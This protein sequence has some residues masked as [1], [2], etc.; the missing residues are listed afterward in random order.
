MKSISLVIFLGSF[1]A[2]F[3]VFLMACTGEKNQQDPQGAGEYIYA[4]TF[5]GEG[6]EGL[7]VFE[8]NRAD[9]SLRPIQTVTDRVGPN[10][11]A[12][13]P[14]KQFLYSVGDDPYNESEPFGTLSAYQ[15]NQENGMLELINEQSV[16]GRNTAHVSVDPLGEFVYVSNYTEGNVVMFRILDNGGV[17]E[18]IDAKQHEGSSINEN[19]QNAPH[20]HQSVPSA[21]GR[22]LYVSDLGIDKIMIYEIDR[23]EGKLVPA[24]EPWFESEPGSG[25]RHLVLHPNGEFV[26]SNE[27]LSVT[28]AALSIDEE[29]GA[30][31][32]I[33]RL[34]M[35]PEGVEG[36]DSMSGADIHIS[37]DGGFLY[38]SVRGENLLAVY[39]IDET[40]GDLSL[41]EHVSTEGNHPRNF[42]VDEMGEF[43]IVANRDSDH[44]V[45]LDRNSE[46]GEL[47]FTGTEAEVP[48]VVCVTQ[49]II[50]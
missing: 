26:Y 40:S 43:A 8:L 30:L 36:D 14:N 21:D 4:G 7:Y 15:I 50:E 45:V 6:S 44:I 25:P 49:L 12:I 3:S 1:T 33:Q 35:L 38:A 39:K 34:S 13:H 19:R 37:P 32:Q 17:S 29:T 46:T 23:E 10:F 42:M 27:E 20:V 22:F 2:L 31:S 28:V 24:S 16:E 41:I 5:E 9:Y 48:V 47:T 18:A 11:Q